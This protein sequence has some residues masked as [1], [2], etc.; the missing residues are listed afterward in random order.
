MQV[1]KQTKIEVTGVEGILELLRIGN[2][3][4]F[5]LTEGQV[6]FS[7]LEIQGIRDALTAVLDGQ[8]GNTEGPWARIEDVPASVHAVI[9]EDGD[10]WTRSPNDPAGYFA[11]ET[12][13]YL[14]NY[15]PFRRA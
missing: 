15:A 12:F 11:G 9:D 4:T 14:N 1:E 7:L 2:T 13:E 8:G 3:V 6:S 5:S 10:T